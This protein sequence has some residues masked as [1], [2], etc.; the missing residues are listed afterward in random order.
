MMKRVL[1]KP[2]ID[3]VVPVEMMAV[4]QFLGYAHT[5]CDYGGN[6]DM[7]GVHGLYIVLHFLVFHN[8]ILYI[9]S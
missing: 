9:A 3:M 8:L 7:H 5:A 2:L 4:G 6:V 1:H